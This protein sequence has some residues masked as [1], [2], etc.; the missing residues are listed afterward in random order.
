MFAEIFIKLIKFY[1]AAL[2]PYLGRN[3]R[4]YPS[5]SEYMILA[6]KKRGFFSGLFLGVKRILKCHRFNPGGVDLPS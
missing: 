1:Q 4:F 5:C 6:I 2:S 3:C